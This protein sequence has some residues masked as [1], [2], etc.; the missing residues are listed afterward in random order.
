MHPLA[1]APHPI[2]SNYGGLVATHELLRAGCSSRQLSRLVAIGELVR[3]RQGWYALPD[4]ER[5]LQGAA[6]VGGILGCVSAARA[7]GLAVRPSERMHISV[8]HASAR[9][10]SPNDHRVRLAR[11]EALTHWT[12]RPQGAARLIQSVPE[13][14]RAMALC[15]PLE[16]TIAA[17]D[18]ALRLRLISHVEWMTLLETLP[19]RLAA[20][21]EQVD[22]RAE[23]ITESIARV[24]LCGLGYL[25]RL[26]VRIPGVGRVDMLLGDRLVLEFD[27]WEYHGD[28]EQFEED[29]RRDAAL[30]ARGYVCLRF[31]YR[32]VIHR[33]HE[34]RAAVAGAVAAGFGTK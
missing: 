10:R 14:L 9:L 7:H 11:A 33:W 34:V 1:P 26:Q 25:P 8:R 27:G 23:S 28:R 18:S 17:A 24:R 13:S 4:L 22:A 31:S 2:V 20:L 30:A 5:T 29:R 6:R 32:Q 12:I 19:A 3:V 16:R 15:Q 21:L